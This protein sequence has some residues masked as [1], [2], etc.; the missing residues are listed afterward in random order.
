MND[1]FITVVMQGYPSKFPVL[2][3]ENGETTCDAVPY[4]GIAGYVTTMASAH[5]ITQVKIYGNNNYASAMADDI[6]N[7]AM[8]EY[9]DSDL[10]IEVISL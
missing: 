10:E 6:K 1:K 8:T 9:S 4:D 2:Y 7:L 5:R 3:T